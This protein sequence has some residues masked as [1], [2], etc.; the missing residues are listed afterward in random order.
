MADQVDISST[1]SDLLEG[2]ADSRHIPQRDALEISVQVHKICAR[3]CMGAR[4]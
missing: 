4:A 2:M 1:W 3:L